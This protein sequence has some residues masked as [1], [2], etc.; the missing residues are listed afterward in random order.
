MSDSTTAI[1]GAGIAGM[2]CA[3]RLKAR[4]QSVILFDKGRRPGGRLASRQ[5]DVGLYDHGAQYFTARDPGFRDMIDGL[6]SAVPFTAR[7][8]KVGEDGSLAVDDD[9]ETRFVGSPDINAIARELATGLDSRSSVQIDAVSRADA[10]WLL[11]DQDGR[12]IGPFDRLVVTVPAPQAAALLQDHA[13]EAA[14]LAS[15]CAYAPCIAVMVT[16]ADVVPLSVDAVR[17]PSGG[18]AVLS[19][20]ARR[21]GRKPESWVLHASP[22]W[23]ADHIDEPPE[24][25]VAPLLDAFA[26]FAGGPETIAEARAH[27]WRYALVTEALGQ[28]FIHEPGLGLGLAGDWCLGP[29]VEAAWLSGDELGAALR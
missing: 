26:G 28:P 4:G 13:P 6:E 5:T 23:S 7:S 24:T 10:G 16:F 29:R 3:R 27:R 1:I 22:G 14:A 18:G 11:S 12:Q 20:A 19:W 15:R 21:P 8:G 17:W 9:G 25:L 2:A